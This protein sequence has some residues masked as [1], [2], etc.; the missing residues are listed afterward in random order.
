MTLAN[1][2]K[3]NEL[4]VG[5]LSVE[6]WVL[7]SLLMLVLLLRV[8]LLLLTLWCSYC[9]NY[10]CRLHCFCKYLSFD[11]VH[12][13]LAVL[14]LLSYLLLLAF[15]LL[16]AV[17][18]LTAFLLLLASLL[19]LVSL[20]GGFG[21]TRRITLSEY[22]N[23]TVIFFCY[24][25]I[26]ISNIVLAYSRNYQTMGYRIKTSTY[27]TIGYRTIPHHKAST[28]RNRSRQCH[29]TKHQLH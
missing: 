20:A 18:L 29:I 24:W 1:S 5:V 6:C 11:S 17:L 27:R 7:A 12:T 23:R 10:C 15:L 26:G 25:T 8:S 13:V 16:L 3:N 9:L 2:A 14:L 19:I 28:K 22:C 4:I 21:R